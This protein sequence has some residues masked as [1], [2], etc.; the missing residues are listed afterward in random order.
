MCKKDLEADSLTIGGA[1]FSLPEWDHLSVVLKNKSF[2]SESHSIHGNLLE[3]EK[4]QTKT[5]LTVDLVS[6]RFSKSSVS[7]L[8]D[9]IL[10][11]AVLLKPILINV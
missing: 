10:L 1:A 8:A 5:F 9:F 3:R 4:G 7:V 11:H 2:E 6:I